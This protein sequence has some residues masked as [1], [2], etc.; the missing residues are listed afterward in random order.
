MAYLAG[1]GGGVDE[2]FDPGFHLRLAGV[3]RRWRQVGRKA[4]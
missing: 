1:L 3:R 2:A 4:G